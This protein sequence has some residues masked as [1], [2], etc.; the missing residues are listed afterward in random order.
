MGTAQKETAKLCIKRE[1]SMATTKMQA[2]II[3][4]IIYHIISYHIFSLAGS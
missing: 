3:Y 4:H 2:H 1:L